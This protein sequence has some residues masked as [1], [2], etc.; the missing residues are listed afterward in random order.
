MVNT[1]LTPLDPEECTTLP[2]SK[3]TKALSQAWK[4]ASEGHD[5][6]Y[7]KNILKVWQEEQVQIEKEIREEEEREA[8]EAEER[9]AR[10]AEE[11]EKAVDEEAKAKKKPK[12]RKS[13]GG[14][15]D[16]EMEDADAPKSTKKRKKEAE[17]D[18][19]GPKVRIFVSADIMIVLTDIPAQEDSKGHQAQRTKD[20]KRRIGIEEVF[21]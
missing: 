6:A 16:V 9:A 8:R 12:S 15:E 1:N 3:M 10:Q 2:N 7:F 13:K 19:D 20:T 17:S 4:I 14:D 5:L 11:A 18:G 21:N